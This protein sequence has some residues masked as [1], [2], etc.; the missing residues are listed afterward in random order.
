[1]FWFKTS[2][3]NHWHM[4]GSLFRTSRF[5]KA[6]HFFELAIKKLENFL[7]KKFPSVGATLDEWQKICLSSFLE[8]LSMRFEYVLQSG[9]I[10]KGCEAMI[11]EM[12][13]TPNWIRVR[14]RYPKLDRLH[15][16]SNFM[17]VIISSSQGVP[18]VRALESLIKRSSV[19]S[20]KCCLHCYI[21]VQHIW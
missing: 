18:S 5:L 19:L 6:I 16:F 15:W 21:L 10:M 9:L 11:F 8:C 2:E 7:L 1:M 17:S 3:R 14:S 13:R 20:W 4:W 12:R